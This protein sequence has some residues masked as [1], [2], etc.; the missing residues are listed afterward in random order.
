[1]I[2]AAQAGALRTVLG[3]ATAVLDSAQTDA[4]L[5][6]ELQRLGA[7]LRPIV[8]NPSNT[9]RNRLSALAD[10]LTGLADRLR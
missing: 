9:T 6:T 4:A 7:S 8:S 5:A 1:M 10:T 3:R 2:D